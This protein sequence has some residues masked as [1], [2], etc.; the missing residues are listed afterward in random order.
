MALSMG[1]VIT[2]CSDDDKNNEEPNSPKVAMAVSSMY[3]GYDGEEQE[4]WLKDVTYDNQGR[5]VSYTNSSG[6]KVSYTYSDTKIVRQCAGYS[7]E[8]Q[9]SNGL[10]V[11]DSYG[12]NYKYDGNNQLT[13][14]AGDFTI[15]WSDGNPKSSVVDGETET[16][17]Y[18]TDANILG[19]LQ[20]IAYSIEF[21]GTGEPLLQAAGFFGSLPKNMLK[22]VYYEGSLS[23]TF[24]YSDYNEYGYP[25][26]M[27]IV[28]YDDDVQTYTF[29]WVKI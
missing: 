10:I 15:K 14:I 2:G 29:T 23:Q 8:F 4:L 5:P 18:Y 24:T 7:E 28:D 13:S 12:T 9:L 17:D 22:S 27:K 11:K 21:I 26:T 25:C 19:C 16:F 20:S 3:G 6:Q 1:F